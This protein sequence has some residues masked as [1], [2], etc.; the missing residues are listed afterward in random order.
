M[1]SHNNQQHCKFLMFLL[2][3]SFS[4]TKTLTVRHVLYL[5]HA[6]NA[7]ATVVAL[8]PEWWEQFL[9]SVVGKSYCKPSRNWIESYQ[10]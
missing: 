4:H 8:S 5:T 9:H 10:I 6:R 2:P 3:V 1:L 7:E